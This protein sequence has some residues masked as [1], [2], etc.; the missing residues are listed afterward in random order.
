MIFDSVKS[1]TMERSLSALWQRA[2]LISHN[3]ANEDT[4]GYKGKRLEFENILQNELRTAKNSRTMNRSQ[5]AAMISRA[6][7]MIYDDRALS[8]RADGNNVNLDNEHIELARVQMQYQAL[9]DKVNG[10]YSNLKYAI[11]GGR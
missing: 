6:P 3:I 4:P 8:V 9:R 11:S 1:A 5:K 2:Q 7:S 10:H